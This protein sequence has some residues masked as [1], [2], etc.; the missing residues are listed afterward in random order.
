MDEEYSLYFENLT[1]Q[2]N[3]LA[4]KKKRCRDTSN[5]KVN[6]AQLMK[7]TIAINYIRIPSRYSN[8]LKELSFIVF[9][10]QNDLLFPT[11]II[12]K[13]HTCIIEH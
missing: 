11:E 8:K 3:M 4:T 2:T 7:K 5:K 12:I 1:K 10:W 13:L 9:H 6:R